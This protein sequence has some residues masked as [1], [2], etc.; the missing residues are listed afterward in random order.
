M[1]F[2]VRWPGQVKPGSRSDQT[3]CFTDMLATFA[4]ITGAKLPAAATRD[5]VSI[6][7]LLRGEDRPVRDVTILSQGRVIRQGAWKLIDHLGS[8][9][10]TKP[11]RIRAKAGGPQGQLYNLD[12]DLGETHN[13]YQANPQIVEE[14][15]KLLAR[16]R[17][18]GRSR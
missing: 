18:E 17:S 8:G 14:L 6:L 12:D 9:G 7:P 4:D 13:L 11:R 3:I 10:F 5:S 2:V 16:V 1:P 15:R